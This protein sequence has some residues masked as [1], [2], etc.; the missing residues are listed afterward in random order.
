MCRL[1][2]QFF[3]KLIKLAYAARILFNNFHALLNQQIWSCLLKWLVHLVTY[4]YA[5]PMYM[6]LGCDLFI[7]CNFEAVLQL[8]LHDSLLSVDQGPSSVSL[9]FP[10]CDCS[11]LFILF[12]F[13]LFYFLFCF[14][15]YFIF[16]FFFRHFFSFVWSLCQLYTTH[17]ID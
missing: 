16:C 6:Y 7:W 2:N 1:L 17:C 4:K 11:T 9:S 14:I 10:G 3:T 13:N 15:F 8:N 12:Y 5:L